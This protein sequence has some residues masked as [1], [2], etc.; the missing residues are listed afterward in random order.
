MDG[1]SPRCASVSGFSLHANVAVPAHDRLRLERLFRYAA[2]PPLAIERLEPLQDGRLLYR[3]K[4]P[5]Q[6]GTTHIVLTPEELIAKLAALVPAPRTNL[7]RYSGVFAP[8]AKWRSKIVPEGP[9]ETVSTAQQSVAGSGPAPKDLEL[10]PPP[11]PHSRNYVWSELMRRV[12]AVDVLQCDRCGGHMRMI[13]SIHPPET[14]RKILE[15]LGLPSRAPPL[16]TAA[17]AIESPYL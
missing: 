7:V 9:A 16:T 8:R 13:C 6:N 10:S 5:W 14:I 17:P 1:T 2:R 11:I 3:F 12:F 15:Y 4:R